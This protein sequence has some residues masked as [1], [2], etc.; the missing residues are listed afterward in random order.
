MQKKKSKVLDI[1][2]IGILVIAL[3]LIRMFEKELFYDAVR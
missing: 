3:M 2:I 1:A